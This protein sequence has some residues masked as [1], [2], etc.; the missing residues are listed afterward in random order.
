MNQQLTG[1]GSQWQEADRV[2]EFVARTDS[3]E[4]MRTELFT[5]L[6]HL[7]PFS[8]D[9]PIRVLDIGSGHGVLAAAVLDAY[10]NARATGLD[11]SDAM[12]EVGRERMARFGDRFHYH[13]GDVSGGDLP[14]DLPGPFDLVVSSLAIHHVP[15]ETKPA[16]FANLHRSIADGGCF[17]D[18]D[19]MRTRDAVIRDLYSGARDALGDARGPR[20]QRMQRAEPREPRPEGEGR[21]EF[22]DAMEDIVAW[23]REA[24]FAHVDCLWKR[25]DYAMVGAFK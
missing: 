13:F 15:T 21:R 20:P 24:G 19:N 16:F 6:T 1:S 4:A 11:L 10:P 25:L 23:L 18:L 22:P 3:V 7:L 9:A 17:I 8:P 5:L 2:K 14:A 12:M